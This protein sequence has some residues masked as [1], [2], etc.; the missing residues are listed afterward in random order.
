MSLAADF[1]IAVFLDSERERVDGVLAR[2]AGSMLNGAPP[3]LE[4][5]VRYALEPGGKRLRPILCVAA[6]RAVRGVDRAP[7]PVYELAAALELVHTYSLVHDD[8]PGMDD[9]DVRRGRPSTHRAFGTERAMLAGVALIPLAC[10]VAVRAGSALGLGEPGQ[11]ALVH[12]LCVAAGAGGMVGGQVAD[13]EAEG[14]SIASDELESMHGRKTGALLTAALRLG[15]RAAEA[16]DDVLRALD[17]YGRS[18][19]LAFQIT[20]DLLD[21]TG[22]PE[23]IGKTGGRDSELAKATFPALLGEEA[24]RRRAQDEVQNALAALAEAGVSSRELE[25]LGRF[26]V[27]RDR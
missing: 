27:E 9:D 17:D 22:R 4:A 2:L 24:A 20:D 16:G 3:V 13:L 7:D 5:P 12:E 21:M 19:G 23:V 25:A 14:R 26:T 11:S 8:L 1:D 10:R 18:I 6:Y 15:G